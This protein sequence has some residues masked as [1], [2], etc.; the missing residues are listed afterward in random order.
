MMTFFA[1]DKNGFG[2]YVTADNWKAA[3]AF[4]LCN[5]LSLMGTVEIIIEAPG[6]N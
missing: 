4:C 5:G 6:I 1:I 2:V 3:E